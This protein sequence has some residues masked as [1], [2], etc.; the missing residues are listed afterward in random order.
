MS[1]LPLASNHLEALKLVKDWSS[2]L[3]IVQSAAIGVIGTFLKQPPAGGYGVLTALLLISLISSIV[4]GAVWVVGAIPNIAQELPSLLQSNP[5]L[6]IYKQRGGKKGDRML[7]T[8]CDIQHSLFVVSL[9]FFSLFVFF[10]P[11]GTE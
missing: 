3:I 11:P 2:G 5:K 8:N 6:S 1:T 9:I 4:V 10:A 7:G